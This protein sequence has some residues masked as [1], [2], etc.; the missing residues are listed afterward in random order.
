MGIIYDGEFSMAGLAF[1]AG[2][3]TSLSRTWRVVSVFWAIF[4]MAPFMALMA[5]YGKIP[6]TAG[7]LLYVVP[8]IF[9]GMA[10]FLIN[11]IGDVEYDPAEKNVI[12]RGDITRTTAIIAFVFLLIVGTALLFLIYRSPMAY[13]AYFAFAALGFT[14]NSPVL[15]LKD[16]LL[17]PLVAAGFLWLSTSTIFLAEFGYFG[18][19]ALLLLAGLFLVFIAY[20]VRHTICDVDVDVKFGSR[21]FAVIMG[22]KRARIVEYALLVMGCGVL[23]FDM[24]YIL[25]F[26]YVLFMAILVLLFV[27][28]IAPELVWDIEAGFSSGYRAAMPF[29]V[30][31]VYIGLM[32]FIILMIP[33]V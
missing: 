27:L 15:R 6:L 11:D 20:E 5:H 31:K 1:L 19:D 4:T 14:Y 13:V 12:T 26:G 3:F 29:F 8:F 28:A 7:A 9:G 10:T 32:A 21:T 22:E 2:S 30:I 16:S 17:G 33:V 23:V 24:F 25:G 18:W